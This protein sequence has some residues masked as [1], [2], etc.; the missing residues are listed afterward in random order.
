[1]KAKAERKKG[2]KHKIESWHVTRRIL[3]SP[4]DGPFEI[5]EVPWASLSPSRVIRGTETQKIQWP[6]PHLLRDSPLW[7]RQLKTIMRRLN[8]SA[9]HHDK[10]LKDLNQSTLEM[11]HHSNPSM[12]FAITSSIS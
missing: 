1:M 7:H 6:A 8:Y 12:P 11:P 10:I 3:R 5:G 2:I 9:S 4:T